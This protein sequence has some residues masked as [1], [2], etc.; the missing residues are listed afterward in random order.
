MTTEV[1][2]IIGEIKSNLKDSEDQRAIRNT[3][4]QP[5]KEDIREIIPNLVEGVI[6][7]QITVPDNMAIQDHIEMAADLEAN[8]RIEAE[9]L[10]P[11]L[12]IEKN[13]PRNQKVI[14]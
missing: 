12:E 9:L 14:W 5:L 1:D 3:S 2:T 7:D 11:V 8:Q 10:A 6:P 4:E 13:R